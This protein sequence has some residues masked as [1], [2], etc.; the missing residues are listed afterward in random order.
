MYIG[1]QVFQLRRNLKMKPTTL[2]II[3]AVVML[4]IPGCE[5]ERQSDEHLIL[6]GKLLNHTDCKEF[7][8]SR[9]LSDISDTLS[10]VDYEFNPSSHKLFLKHINAGFNCCPESLYCRISLSSDT[11]FV[12][13][14][15][16]TQGCHCNCLYDLEIEI[17]GVES[18]KY[19]INF[20]E[21]YAPKGESINFEIDLTKKI[22]GS[23]CVTRK[24][25]PWGIH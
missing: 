2:S 15:E 11:I 4:L 20:A 24:N 25:Y 18:K 14:F 21:P 12:Q 1:L 8:S 5:T 6:T 7:K 10:C 19:Q 3:L 22:T 23:Y 17:N 9:I 13:E 16:Q